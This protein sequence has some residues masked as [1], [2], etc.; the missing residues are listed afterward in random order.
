MRGLAADGDLSAMGTVWKTKYGERRVRHDPP[1]IEEALIAAEC[2]TDDLNQQ[3]EIAAELMG[4]PFEDVFVIADKLSQEKTKTARIEAMQGETRTI[5]IAPVKA[6]SG[7]GAR[8]AARTI[9]VER[10]APRRIVM[11]KSIDN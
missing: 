2:L 7:Q 6:A 10:K 4:L 8:P 9:V 3:V 1:T 5:S 11:P